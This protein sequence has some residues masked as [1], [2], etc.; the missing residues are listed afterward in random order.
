MP[1]PREGLVDQ[2]LSYLPNPLS[3]LARQRS[4]QRKVRDLTI[5]EESPMILFPVLSLGHAQFG[6]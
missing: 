5:D 4:G 1:L 2:P 6:I 3:A